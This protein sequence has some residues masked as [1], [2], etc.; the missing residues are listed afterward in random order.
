MIQINFKNMLKITKAKPNPLGKDK[1]SGLLLLNK[2]LG[3]E[4]IDIK[5]TSTRSVLLK[6][7]QIYHMIYKNGQTEWEIAKNFSNLLNL[8]LPAGLTMR[9]HSGSGP[10]SI[11]NFEDI[12]GADYHY[13]TGKGYIWN[14]DKIDRPMV[15]DKINKVILDQT[16]Y[17]APVVDGKILIR[18]NDKLI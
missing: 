10:S 17:D 9:I 12:F 15:Y 2:K 13:F 1:V 8:I 18:V 7:I 3:A 14:N 5:N 6:N 11:L 16:Y 4:W